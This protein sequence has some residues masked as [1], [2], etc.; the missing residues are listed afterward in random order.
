MRVFLSITLFL[1]TFGIHLKGIFIFRRMMDQVNGVLQ[2]NCQ[3]PEIG[4]SW[5]QGKVIKL[6]RQ[7]FPDSTLRKELYV[8]WCLTTATFLSAL[9][10]IVEF[11]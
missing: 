6:H 1:I 4:P 7:F 3:I 2:A 9:A 10:C 8:F 11:R 5:L